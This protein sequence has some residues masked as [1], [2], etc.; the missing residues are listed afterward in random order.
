MCSAVYSPSVTAVEDT[1]WQPV[2]SE[3]L[4]R[5]PAVYLDKYVEHDFRDSSLSA[6]IVELDEQ[7]SLQLQNMHS[8]RESIEQASG[9]TKVEL[10]HQL[11]V[12]KSEYMDMIERKQDLEREAFETRIGVY[13]RT[14]DR[15]QEKKRIA[16]D[17]MNKTLIASQ[18]QA[19]TRMQHATVMVDGILAM[20]S[21]AAKTRYAEEYTDNLNRIEELKAAIAKHAANTGPAIEGKTVTRENYLRYLMANAESQLAILDQERLMLTYMSRLVALDAHA[22]EQEILFDQDS[23]EI[24]GISS[25]QR[26]LADVADIFIE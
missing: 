2:S 24:A 18:Q 14:L 12:A 17:H 19:R 20:S 8:L 23:T 7:I 26:R 5:L 15:I 11:L 21:D 3:Q 9:E 4:V 1:S 6:G 13:S 25:D 10:R 16:Q 22:L